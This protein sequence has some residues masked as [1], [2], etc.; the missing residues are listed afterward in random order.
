MND[1]FDLDQEH[2]DNLPSL[3]W[4]YICWRLWVVLGTRYYQPMVCGW[5]M[6]VVEPIQH[7]PANHVL[8]SN[9]PN[10]SIHAI[11]KKQIDNTIPSLKLTVRTWEWMVGILV[12]FWHGLFSRAICWFWGVYIPVAFEGAKYSHPAWRGFSTS[13]SKVPKLPKLH[14]KDLSDEFMDP[15]LSKR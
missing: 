15:R 5:L 1:T 12:S 6:L 7:Q 8:I 4:V 10:T 13:I 2:Y 9:L 14:G 11:L 3:N